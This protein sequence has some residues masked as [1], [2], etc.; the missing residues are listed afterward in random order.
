[1]TALSKVLAPDYLEHF[2]CD[3]PNC[4]DN[5]CQGSWAIHVDEGRYK[6]LK[7]INIKE[8]KTVVDETIKRNRS[9]PTTQTFGKLIL[10]KKIGQCQFLSPEKLCKLQSTM[11][12]DYLPNVCMIYPRITNNILGQSLERSLTLSCPLA[13]ELVL[14]KPE[15]WGFSVQ[16][17]DLMG[18]EM[19]SMDV[20]PK[21]KI[22]RR[23][24]FPYFQELR[25]FSVQ[26]LK[27]RDLLL[28]QRLVILGMFLEKVTISIELEEPEKIPALIEQYTRMIT[29][30]LF[31]EAL[32]AIPANYVVQA[33]LTFLI[34]KRKVAKGASQGF[35][36]V[37]N[38]AMK[39]LQYRGDMQ[40][41]HDKQRYQSA[42]DDWYQPFFSEREYILE[43][44]LVN[45]IFANLFP[46]NRDTV[47]DS[48][49]MMVLHYAVIKML[50]IGNA[51]FHKEAFT[52]QMAAHVIQKFVKAVEHSPQFVKEIY[53]DF[54]QQGWLTM[55]Y[56]A[57]LIRN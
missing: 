42:H 7:K 32:E 13:A 10:D 4:P 23:P 39:G 57:I 56:M 51:A 5:C 38:Q 11:G 21:S 17:M 34:A 15:G 19:Y 1:M 2:R 49:A 24:V 35:L 29:E 54:K 27:T 14:L 50:L 25:G 8:I 41:E 33:K 9:N 45:H 36:D 22:A 52:E 55:P 3:G 44:Y 31:S 53:G 46:L 37:A 30:G 40:S 48:Y 16:E 28:W 12:A 47:F 20:G 6:K 43:N 26:I 18:R